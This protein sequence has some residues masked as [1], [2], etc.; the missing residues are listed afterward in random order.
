MEPDTDHDPWIPT[1]EACHGHGVPHTDHGTHGLLEKVRTGVGLGA[2]KR[3]LIAQ[4]LGYKSL[5]GHAARRLGSLSHY[6]LLER[7]GKG[8]ARISAL[9]KAILMPTSD[10]EKTQAI[11]V[12]ARTPNLYSALLA[13][14]TGHALPTMLTNLLSREHGVSPT[15]AEDAANTFRET[16]EFAGLLRNGVLVAEPQDSPSGES[17]SKGGTVTTP[18]ASG[19]R[20]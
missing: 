7:A 10:S 11:G 14:H 1:Y 12:A 13:K 8:A 16:M 2:A 5:S 9:G 3:E 17:G 20:D 6:G 18:A 4:A 15:G 19:T